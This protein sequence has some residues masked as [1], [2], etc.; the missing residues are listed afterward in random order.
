MPEY[1]REAHHPR[2]T[3]KGHDL[4][5]TL[6]HS[7]RE[8]RIAWLVGGE[9]RSVNVVERNSLGVSSGLAA[10]GEAMGIEFRAGCRPTTR[11]GS[12]REWTAIS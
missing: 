5:Y 11:V 4:L 12:F 9:W 7:S 8:S 2:G 1:Q 3:I 6:G 10:M